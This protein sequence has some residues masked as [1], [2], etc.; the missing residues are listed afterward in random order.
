MRVTRT[1]IDYEELSIT[2]IHT[3]MS[4]STTTPVITGLACGIALVVLFSFLFSA[5]ATRSGISNN[6][7]EIGKTATEN[8]CLPKN[9]SSVVVN[10]PV[11]QPAATSM[12]AGFNLEGVDYAG[13]SVIMFY[14]DYSLC[15]NTESFEELIDKGAIFISV[16]K[17][18]EVKDSVQFQ[19]RELQ[20][21][22][23]HTETLAKVEPVTVNGNKG[24]GWEPFNG[25]DTVRIDGNVVKQEPVK[26][27]GW[28][29]FYDD[30]DGTLYGIR[31][32]QPLQELMKIA[33][34]LH[35]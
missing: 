14:T 17:Y 35:S 31:G 5:D 11:K 15:P 29:R 20:Y 19:T 23:N 3:R 10:F 21:Y 16:S 33:E 34:S 28:I 13:G 6:S 24:V 25:T 12:P 2:I 9:L 30:Q 18:D 8:A 22:T 4:G 32:H 1:K 26:M 27:P 7:G